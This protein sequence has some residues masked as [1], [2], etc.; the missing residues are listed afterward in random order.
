MVILLQINKITFG[1]SENLGKKIHIS[2]NLAKFLTKV[3]CFFKKVFFMVF[4]L[5]C[6]GGKSI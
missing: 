2:Q 1:K 4:F 5:N 6:P 3:C